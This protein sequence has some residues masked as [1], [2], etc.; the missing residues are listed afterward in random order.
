[1]TSLWLEPIEL[2]GSLDLQLDDLDLCVCRRRFFPF[3]F[4]V[5]RYHI[6]FRVSSVQVF[7]ESRY[8]CLKAL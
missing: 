7:S 2:A 8:K 3:F 5:I 6:T 1:M 4:I